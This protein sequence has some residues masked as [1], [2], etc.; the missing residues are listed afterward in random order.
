M[1]NLEIKVVFILGKSVC[2]DKTGVCTKYY[3]VCTENGLELA[4]NMMEEASHC[5][6]EDRTH[7]SAKIVIGFLGGHWC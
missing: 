7:V 4:R 3:K 2:T 6:I 1:K 5:L